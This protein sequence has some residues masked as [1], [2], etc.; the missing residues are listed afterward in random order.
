VSEC[1]WHLTQ[2]GHS[3]TAGPPAT[4]QMLHAVGTQYA[5]TS[6]QV[7]TGTPKK[8]PVPFG[9]GAEPFAGLAGESHP[10]SYSGLNQVNTNFVSGKHIGV[11]VVN[12]AC[13]HGA[14]DG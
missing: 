8:A 5:R 2:K 1:D 13:K 7:N 4:N 10:V 3:P 9:T 12:S 14:G 6:K 11:G